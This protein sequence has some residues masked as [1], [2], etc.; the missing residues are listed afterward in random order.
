M[1][2]TLPHHLLKPHVSTPTPPPITSSVLAN[3]L[4]NLMV[5]SLRKAEVTKQGHQCV[6]RSLGGKMSESLTPGWG[7][8]V[9]GRGGFGKDC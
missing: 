9:G 3:L 2:F 6:G 8:G 7:L 1:A 5:F 4:F